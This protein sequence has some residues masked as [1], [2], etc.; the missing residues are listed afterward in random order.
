MMNADMKSAYWND[1]YTQK[2]K[3][4]LTY[5]SHSVSANLKG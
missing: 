1:L 3:S 4:A 5:P 2:A